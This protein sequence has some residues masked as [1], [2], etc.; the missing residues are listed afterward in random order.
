MPSP[1]FRK[2]VDELADRTES[3]ALQWSLT[4]SDEAFRADV[5]VG[6]IWVVRWV[7]DYDLRWVEV[8]LVDRSGE[9]VDELKA[10][11]APG[12]YEQDYEDLESI[13][14]AARASAR[15]SEDLA[16]AILKQLDKGA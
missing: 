14:V 9:T 5:G 13:F 6:S 2:L 11:C 3:G 1:S 15:G 10:G 4:R 7:D 8:S 12:A 16:G